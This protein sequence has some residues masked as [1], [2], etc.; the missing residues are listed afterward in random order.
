MNVHSFCQ[1]IFTFPNYE[2]ICCMFVNAHTHIPNSDQNTLS[3][4]NLYKDFYRA[5]DIP[6]VSVGLHP[7]YIS[8]E[9]IGEQYEALQNAAVYENV[10]AIG[11]CGLDRLMTTDWN[12]QLMAFERQVVLAEELNKPMIIHCVKAFQECMQVLKGVKVPIVFHG[13]NH[14]WAT[15]APLL[16]A[17]YYISFGKSFNN[18]KSIA[19]DTFLHSPLTQVFFETDDAIIDVASIYKE[20]AIVKNIRE[21]DIVLQLYTNYKKVFLSK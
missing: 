1:N 6:N 10:I 7:W 5:A 2:Y 19:R 14:K 4:L 18:P 12:L 21:A 8:M 16:E 17:G 3:I 20:A 13:I 9:R 15:I 11:E